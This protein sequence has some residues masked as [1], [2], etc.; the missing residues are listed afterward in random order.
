MP[1]K[2]AR[3]AIAE[4]MELLA[5]QIMDDSDIEEDKYLF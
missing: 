4:A 5:E 3:E 2:V 1:E